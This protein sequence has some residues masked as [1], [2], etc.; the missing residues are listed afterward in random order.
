M[1]YPRSRLLGLSILTETS[2]LLIALLLAKIFEIR[3]PIFT[4][5]PLMTLSVSAIGTLPPLLMFVMVFSKKT[6]HFSTV[7]DLRRTL[8]T[9]V[10]PLFSETRVSDILLISVLAGVCEEVLFRGVLQQLI[11]ILPASA[12]FGLL[13]ALSPTYAV[14]AGLMGLYL[15][16]LFSITQDIIV[17]VL[18]HFLYDLGALM[19]LH[20]LNSKGIDLFE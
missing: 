16:L 3:F 7:L 5:N 17:P 9:V 15:G 11:G 4:T 20:H 2:A 6:Q 12:V 10:S 13:H 14:L 8:K 19:T 18:V 1:G